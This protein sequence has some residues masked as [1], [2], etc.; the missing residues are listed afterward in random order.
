MLS[1]LSTP[2]S[3]KNCRDRLQVPLHLRFLSIAIPNGDIAHAQRFYPFT[4]QCPASV[5]HHA[6]SRETAK[7]VFLVDLV[8]CL[9]D[10]G[11]DLFFAFRR[12]GPESHRPQLVFAVKR[13]IGI[14]RCPPLA[15]SIL[16]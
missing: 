11:P 3:M 2:S 12:E 7:V 4:A 16:Q 5:Q 10:N 8:T 13:V 14:D 15:Q 1:A 9:Q 6:A